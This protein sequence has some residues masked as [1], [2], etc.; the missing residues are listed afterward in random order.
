MV[1]SDS[2]YRHSQ[3]ALR[4]HSNHT[5][6][7]S[8]GKPKQQV[9]F[10]FNPKFMVMPALLKACLASLTL[11]WELVIIVTVYPHRGGSTWQEIQALREVF[12]FIICLLKSLACF[13]TFTLTVCVQHKTDNIYLEIWWIVMTFWLK[14]SPMPRT[15]LAFKALKL[16][17]LRHTNIL[18]DPIQFSPK[19]LQYKTLLWQSLHKLHVIPVAG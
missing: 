14:Y 12:F 13:Y 6:W 10:I 9:Q 15:K 17:V 2:V 3:P 5:L 8:E 1:K 16:F 19:A 7:N 4:P 11:I 18:H